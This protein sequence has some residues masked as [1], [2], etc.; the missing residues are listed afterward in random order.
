MGN[1]LAV[2]IYEDCN[3]E[4]W[5]Q[6]VKQSKNGTF[7]L[8]TDYMFYHQD[9]FINYPLIVRKNGKIIAL[10]PGNIKDN[11]FYSHQGLTYGGLIISVN[12]KAE[13]VVDC[14]NA[15]NAFLNNKGINKVIYKAIPYIYTKAPSMEDEYALFLLNAKQISCGIS[16]AIDLRNPLLLSTLRKR[17]VKKGAKEDLVIRRNY[18]YSDYWSILTENLNKTHN[19]QPVHT[20]SEIKLLSNRFP[21]HIHLYTVYKDDNCVAGVVVYESET[22]AHLQ[23]IS[24]NQAG[25][26]IGA[27]DYLIYT[28]MTETFPNKSYI[29]FGVSVEKNGHYLNKG[30]IFHKQGFGARGVVYKH[31]EY[32][33]DMHITI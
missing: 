26:A 15:I 18:S 24:T 16:S 6:F 25:R 28:L 27:L 5:D 11:I 9:R 3:K 22:V 13:E 21:D 30:L 8:L 32:N 2:F 17:M 12:T 7:L 20:L 4:E 19:V 14:F 10:M 1:E 31:F 23:Y 33:T 29:D